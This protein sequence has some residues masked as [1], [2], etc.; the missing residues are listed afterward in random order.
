MTF[1]KKFLRFSDLENSTEIREAMKFEADY[2]KIKRKS[3][4]IRLANES[5]AKDNQILND[6][7]KKGKQAEKTQ[8]FETAISFY[9]SCLKLGQKSKHLAL[10]NFIHD[11]NRLIVLY[12][13]TNQNSQLKKLLKSL[14]SEY[15][16]SNHSIEWKIRLNKISDK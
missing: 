9:K 15:S 3:E 1:I 11:I 8:D 13:K 5:W 16:N 2:R 6:L 7:R 4:E 10:I 14:L 12:T